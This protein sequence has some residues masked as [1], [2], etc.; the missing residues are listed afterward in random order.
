MYIRR[1]EP[2]ELRT[3]ITKYW[4]QTTTE[5]KLSFPYL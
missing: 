2:Q 1:E 3:K 5:S 4:L